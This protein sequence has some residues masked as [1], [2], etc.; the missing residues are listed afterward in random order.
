[1][2]S[3]CAH[4]DTKKDASDSDEGLQAAQRVVCG[5]SSGKEVE[6]VMTV[7]A[8]DNTTASYREAGGL[9]AFLLHNWAFCT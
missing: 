8:A 6:R 2:E 5:V 7:M 4:Y 3:V 9:L 1:M